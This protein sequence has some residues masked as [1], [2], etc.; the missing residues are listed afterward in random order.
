MG[1][2]NFYFNDTLYALDDEGEEFLYDDTKENI[3]YSLDKFEDLEHV[4][5]YFDGDTSAKGSRYYEGVVAVE[6]IGKI[7]IDNLVGN[8][9]MNFTIKQQIVLRG[10]YYIGFNLDRYFEDADDQYCKTVEEMK[11]HFEY[12]CDDYLDLDDCFDHEDE[13]NDYQSRL[14]YIEEVVKPQYEGQLE[15]IAK[16]FHEIYHSLGE[17]FFSEYKVTSQFSNGETLYAKA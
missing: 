3:R 16:Q 10:G 8:N 13:D 1:T 5:V 14:K 7:N 12:Y 17:E 4:D 15:A 2:S 6:C 9:S 11:N